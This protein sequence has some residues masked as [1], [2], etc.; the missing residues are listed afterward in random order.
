MNKSN[1]A[2]FHAFENESIGRPI[3]VFNSSSHISLVAELCGHLSDISKRKVVEKM[4]LFYNFENPPHENVMSGESADIRVF[5]R[6][7]RGFEFNDL[8]LILI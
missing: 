8:F 6:F 7:F 1:P 2:R 3:R 4:S 5:S